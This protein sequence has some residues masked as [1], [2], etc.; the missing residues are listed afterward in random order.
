MHPED[1]QYL[2]QNSISLSKF[3]RNNVRKLKETDSVL[4]TESV[5]QEPTVKEGPIIDT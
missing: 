4:S 2:E 5:S 3:M 1:V